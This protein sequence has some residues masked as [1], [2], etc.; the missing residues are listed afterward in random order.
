MTKVVPVL[1]SNDSGIKLQDLVRKIGE[2]LRTIG[3]FITEINT[4]RGMFWFVC[5]F[6]CNDPS[7]VNM[8]DPVVGRLDHIQ[9]RNLAH[10][11]SLDQ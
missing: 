3:D 11:R 1:S 6:A 4:Y 7:I 9:I 2:A 10:N 8:V 5:R